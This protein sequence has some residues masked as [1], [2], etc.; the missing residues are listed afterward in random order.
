MD[1]KIFVG[2]AGESVFVRNCSGCTFY[3]ACKQWG[4]VFF[5]VGRTW[6]LPLE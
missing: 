1:S 4:A 5:F 6:T 3:V 2:S